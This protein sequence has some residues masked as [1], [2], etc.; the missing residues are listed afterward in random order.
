MKPEISLLVLGMMLLP[1]PT[2]G[3][4]SLRLNAFERA[5]RR[6]LQNVAESLGLDPSV[7]ESDPQH[8]HSSEWTFVEVRVRQGRKTTLSLVG[9]C[10][11]A[12]SLILH[13]NV[14]S[15]QVTCPSVRHGPRTWKCPC[16]KERDPCAQWYVILA[17]T[18]TTARMKY[19]DET[20]LR[21]RK[22]NREPVLI[23]QTKCV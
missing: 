3:S 9:F 11:L 7:I 15:N 5:K 14:L 19:L 1:T 18:T 4:A 8:V 17:V 21:H 16:S 2:Q 20:S 13:S 10:L 22:P 23:A 6:Q 12:L